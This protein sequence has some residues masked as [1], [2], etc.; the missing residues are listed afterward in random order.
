MSDDARRNATLST[1]KRD[2]LKWPK[3][4]NN[5]F[6]SFPLSPAQQRLWLLDQFEPGNPS[7]NISTTWHLHGLL[8][9]QVLE[10]SLNIIIQRHEILRAT[11][12]AT[13]EEPVQVIAPHLILSIPVI[14]LSTL[15]GSDEQETEAQGQIAFE[16]QRSFDLAQGPLIRITLLRL[17][18]TEHILLVTFHHIIADGWSVGVFGQEL[19]ILYTSFLSNGIPNKLDQL[20]ELPIQYADYAVWQRGLLESGAFN[21]QAEYWKQQLQDAP[22]LLELPTD[23]PRPATQ[24]FRGS[25]ASLILSSAL[26]R[27]LHSLGRKEGATLFMVMMAMFKLLLSRYTGQ[28]DIVV[29]SPFANREQAEVEG[30]IGF[31]LSTLVLRTDLSGNPSFR[32][33][34]SRVRN[35]CLDAYEHLDVPFDYLIAELNPERHLSHNPLFQV[36][37]NFI[38]LDN[39]P[40]RTLEWPGLK[41]EFHIPPEETAKFDLALYAQERSDSI[42]LQLVYNADLFTP[43]R[44]RELLAQFE[45]LAIQAVAHPEQRIDQFS[46]VTPQARAVL[47]DPTAPLSAAWEGAVHMLFAHQAEQVPDQIAATDEH[48]AWSYRELNTRCTQLAN[49]LLAHGIQAH[50]LVAIYAHR[51]VPLIWAILGTLRAG[52][53]YLI[54]DPTYPALR[55]VEYVQQANVRGFIQLEA[56]GTLPAALEEALSGIPC[57]IQLSDQSAPSA[58]DELA[59]YPTSDPGV[60][61]GPDDLACISFTSGSTGRPKGILQLHR[62]LSHFLP[63]QQRVFHLTDNDRYSMLSGL[64]H[65]PLQRDIF[66]PL[67]LG[68]TTCVPTAEGITAPGWLAAWM[69]QEHIS[70]AT[71]TPP[72]L[73]LLTQSAPADIEIPS[74]RWAFIVGDMLTKH[75]VAALQRLAP[76]VTC[77]NLYGTTETQRASGYYIISDERGATHESSAQPWVAQPTKETIPIG[78]GL[79]D[80]QLLVLNRSQHLAGISEL[81]EICFRSPHLAKGYLADDTLTQERFISNPFTQAPNDRLYRTGDLGRYR[82]DGTIDYLGRNDYQV[83]IRGFRIE[84]GEIEA[85]LRPHPAVQEVVVIDREISRGNEPSSAASQSSTKKQEPGVKDKILVAYVVPTQAEADAPAL[86]EQL[87]QFLRAR[88]PNYMMPSAYMLLESLPLLPNRKLDRDALPPPIL[89]NANEAAANGIPRTT[90]EELLASLWAEVLGLEQVSIHDNFFEIGGHSLLAT[91][92]MAHISSTFN[93]SL[94]LRALFEAPTIAS[95]VPLLEQ[96]EA[97]H[98]PHNTLADNPLVRGTRYKGLARK[99]APAS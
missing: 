63:L 46:L 89:T 55:L 75:D 69:Q 41:V 62:S 80:A 44:M 77:V 51:S 79:R 33:L 71:L 39:L 3:T 68:A 4:E 11:F 50:D 5:A 38:N 26:T 14:D 82:P 22:A 61:V 54:L 28:E 67:C 66:T 24:T 18:K 7:Y 99:P 88:L 42:Q 35:V 76:S 8:D 17:S 58:S 32:E 15:P 10:Q 30:L 20:P 73:R 92:L 43:A 34:L 16:D 40:T 93:V 49:Y 56:A 6:K 29:G 95:F 57:R 23:Y 64:A 74:L 65:D 97:S 81:G 85:M 19:T 36:F 86:R 94:P 31:F 90:T 83:K 2:V 27:A 53:A 45:Q 13:G 25:T 60:T 48:G 96:Q 47:P 1:K 70:I 84:L 12:V 59:H 98:A 87:G 52:A 9:V 21:E 91:Q 72:M 37:F 78:R